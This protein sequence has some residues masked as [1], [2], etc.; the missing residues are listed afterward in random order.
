PIMGR[1]FVADEDKPSDGRVVILSERL[2]RSRFNSDPS[3]LNQTITLDGVKFTVIGVMP[4]SFEFPI[5]N[6]P[7]ELWT[8]IAGEAAGKTPIT[9]QRGAHFSSAIGRLKPN[10][11][12]EQAQSELTAI[13]ARLE[14]QYPDT[15]THKSL[16]LESALTALIGDI[17]PAL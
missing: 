5:Q 2:F 14:K 12:P 7:A 9:A 1:T 11:T 15:N 13:G 6:E 17:R 4:A 16:R 10:V 8:T 3:L